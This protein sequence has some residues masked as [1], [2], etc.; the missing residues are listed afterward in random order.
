V[1]GEEQRPG[2]GRLTVANMGRSGWPNRSRCCVDD[3]HQDCG[4]VSLAVRGRIR[5]IQ[6]QSTVTLCECSCHAACT[7]AGRTPV[8]LTVWQQLCECPGGENVRAWTDEPRQPR[9]GFRGDHKEKDHQWRED[10]A[11]RRQAFRAARDAAAGKT[12]QELRDLY[13][14]ELRSRGQVVLPQ[15]NH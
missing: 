4:H 9:P 14:A 8:P 6:S 1:V 15:E 7:L 3:A 12:R 2:S 5:G 11:A 10:T 13:I